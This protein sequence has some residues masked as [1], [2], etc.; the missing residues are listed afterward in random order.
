MGRRLVFSNFLVYAPDSGNNL[1]R[2]ARAEDPSKASRALV[3]WVTDSDDLPLQ[4]RRNAETGPMFERRRALLAEV[5]TLAGTVPDT[6]DAV[7]VGAFDWEAL[8]S[9]LDDV[10]KR[11]NDEFPNA[12]G[13][14]HCTVLQYMY[15]LVGLPGRK[16][17]DATPPAP[18]PGVGLIE[19]ARVRLVGLAA[20]AYNGLQG[21]VGARRRDV[22]WWG[23]AG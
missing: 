21:T 8:K 6:I 13:L 17:S 18:A 3:K 9:S 4:A 5:V 11:V 19:G 23:G 7:T 12:A 20:V 1:D 15:I 16:A 10:S 14:V 2:R 22:P